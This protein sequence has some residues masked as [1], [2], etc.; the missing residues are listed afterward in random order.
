MGDEHPLESFMRGELVWTPAPHERTF[1]P[2]GVY[3]Q[4]RERVEKVAW[5]GRAYYRRE[6]QGIERH[7]AHRVRDDGDRVVCSLWALDT[8]LED[9][10]VLTPA[11]DVVEVRVPTLIT[12]STRPLPAPTAAGLVAIVVASSAPPLAEAIR[13]EAAGLAF[14]WAPVAGDLATLD[15]GRARVSTGLLRALAARLAT[16]ESRAVQVRLGFAALAAAAHALAGGVTAFTEGKIPL[17]KLIQEAATPGGIAATVMKAMDDAGYYR[18][19][20]RGVHAG[21]ALARAIAR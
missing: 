7:G 3:V 11:G 16:A 1:D 19:I 10:L 4:S 8:P 14:E 17:E 6:W 18:I 20:E 9:H 12:G 5:R 21:V 15:G 2:R 13:A